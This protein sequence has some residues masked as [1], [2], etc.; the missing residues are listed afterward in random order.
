VVEILPSVAVLNS[1]E[2]LLLGHDLDRVVLATADTIREY[3]QTRRSPWKWLIRQL[4]V[5]Q[6]VSTGTLSRR[7]YNGR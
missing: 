2:L 5:A 3:E 1:A 6:M 4:I 7:S